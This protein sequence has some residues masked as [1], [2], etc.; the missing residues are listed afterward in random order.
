MLEFNIT[1]TPWLKVPIKTPESSDVPNTEESVIEIVP[2]DESLYIAPI[3][4]AELEEV[5]VQS[6]TQLEI[7]ISA[8][9]Y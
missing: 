3:I 9:L 1:S 6:T 4:P 5:N 8:G 7:I 2:A